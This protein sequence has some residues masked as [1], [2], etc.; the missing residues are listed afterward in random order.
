MKKFLLL[1][2]AA[3]TVTVVMAQQK[4]NL[5]KSPVE[6]L[7]KK[8]TNKAFNTKVVNLDNT[9]TLK[10]LK[11]VSQ[12]HRHQRELQTTTASK[13]FQSKYMS[14][15]TLWVSL[16]RTCSLRSNTMLLTKKPICLCMAWIIWKELLRQQAISTVQWVPTLSPSISAQ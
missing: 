10:Q 16:R 6:N 11:A 3:A 7:V 2:L 4:A 5:P 1:T 15:T 8:N 12:R 14:S 13:V 9:I